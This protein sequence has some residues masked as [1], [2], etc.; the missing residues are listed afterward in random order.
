MITSFNNHEI[1]VVK[2]KHAASEVVLLGVHV[3]LELD[4]LV[5][6]VTNTVDSDMNSAGQI[7]FKLL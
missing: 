6:E 7:L 4:G 5:A 3:N 2:E 1:D